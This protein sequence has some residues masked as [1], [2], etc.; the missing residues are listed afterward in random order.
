MCALLIIL[1]ILVFIGFWAL[2]LALIVLGFLL[3]MALI[4]SVL[5]TFFPTIEDGGDE[6]E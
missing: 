6:D 3:V 4:A 5:Q 1:P 2:K